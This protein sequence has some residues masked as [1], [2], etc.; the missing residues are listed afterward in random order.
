MPAGSDYLLRG[1]LPMRKAVRR[2]TKTG[3]S[4]FYP[5]CKK[6]P[7]LKKAERFFIVSKAI[8]F[9][10]HVRGGNPLRLRFAVLPL[11]YFIR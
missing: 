7:S 1:G 5:G 11:P 2:G 9:Y 3:F 8:G 4:C 10:S 6:E